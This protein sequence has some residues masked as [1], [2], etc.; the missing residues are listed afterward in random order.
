MH[1]QRSHPLPDAS[2]PL[3]TRDLVP[4]ES[5]YWLIEWGAMKLL[6]RQRETHPATGALNPTRMPE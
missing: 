5:V 1:R 6:H 2:W 3:H 4:E